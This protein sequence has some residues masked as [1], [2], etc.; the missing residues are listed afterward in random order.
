M[1]PGIRPRLQRR[2]G[3]GQQAVRT[4]RKQAAGSGKVGDSWVFLS[5]FVYSSFMQ[6]SRV[7][8]PAI[9]DFIRAGSWENR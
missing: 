4:Y 8:F 3:Y 9:L 1:N 6:E 7:G 2:A 5:K